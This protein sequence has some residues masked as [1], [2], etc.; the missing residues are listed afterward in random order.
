MDPP[1][2]SGPAPLLANS[3]AA[4]SSVDLEAL[5]AGLVRGD[6]AAYRRFYDLYFQRLFRYLLV[7]TGGREEAAQDALQ[8]TLMRVVRHIRTFDSESIFWSWLAV[9]AR[10]AL[11]DE[12]RKRARYLRF[13]DRFFLW[14]Q[15]APSNAD[16]EADA[17]LL[18]LLDTHLEALPPEDRALLE[19]KYLDGQSVREIATALDTSEKAV[20]S[21]LG[22]VRRKLKDLILAQLHDE[23]D[24]PS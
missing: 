1:R 5:T 4:P 23:T 19:Q 8:L 6:E 3:A 24:T 15:P 13:L 16:H 9:L 2:P 7:L 12:E 14:T 17:R 11:I 10:S 20:E 22:R 18:A 21:R